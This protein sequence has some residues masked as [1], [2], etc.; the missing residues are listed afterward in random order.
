MT[1]LFV[2]QHRLHLVRKKNNESFDDF[3]IKHSQSPYNGIL[4]N[5]GV[6]YR[7]RQ[8]VLPSES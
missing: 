1:N 4:K 2:G 5:N 6:I 3:G 7:S 8:S